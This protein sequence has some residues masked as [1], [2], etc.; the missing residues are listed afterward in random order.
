MVAQ[1][2][3]P[4]AEALKMSYLSKDS[5]QKLHSLLERI[6]G[7]MKVYFEQCKFKIV[8][9]IES[10]FS[11]EIRFYILILYFNFKNLF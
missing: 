4:T 5:I 6:Y 11:V 3:L 7:V 9:F 2:V 8:V 1:D 10:V